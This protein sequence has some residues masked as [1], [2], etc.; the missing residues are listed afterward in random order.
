M[1]KQNPTPV[2]LLQNAKNALMPGGTQAQG[3]SGRTITFIFHSK[4]PPLPL[5]SK[6]SSNPADV[7]P[8]NNPPAPPDLHLPTGKVDESL[9]CGAEP[10]TASVESAM[11][12]YYL[13][14][15][16]KPDG[17]RQTMVVPGQVGAPWMKP[18]ELWLS[19]P[20]TS[21]G[22]PGCPGQGLT[23]LGLPTRGWGNPDPPGY[24]GQRQHPGTG[25]RYPGWSGGT[26]GGVEVPGSGLGGT[27]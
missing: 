7:F 22:N 15:W 13:S 6:A 11:N 21:W 18:G 10:R 9:S 17:W 23:R 8:S 24:P 16:S 19:K 26:R 27:G 20:R 2:A 14:P 5:Q 1:T 3:C 12:L 4:D 25:R